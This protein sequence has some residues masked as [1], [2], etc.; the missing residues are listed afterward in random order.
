MEFTGWLT[1]EECAEQLRQSDGLILPSLHECGGAVVLEAMATGLPV[2]ATDWGGPADYLD[3]SC[4]TL[5]KPT[6]KAAFVA[7]LT[8]AM[9]ELANSFSRRRT[10]GEAGRAKV[11]AQFG[12]PDK[13]KSMI[14]IH[15]DAIRRAN[16]N[17]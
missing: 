7:G 3:S 14:E 16:S 13:I 12:W 17:A 5:V 4:G 1:Q 10:L 11:M 2:I 8:A 9:T 15:R 6:S